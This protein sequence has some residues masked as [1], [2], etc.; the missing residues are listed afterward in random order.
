[1][2]RYLDDEPVQ[3]CP[4]SAGYRFRKFARRNKAVLATASVVAVAV[5][6]AVAVL[7]TS[8]V[9]IARALQAET[10]AKGELENAL[11][12][13]RRE[14]YFQR[15][16]LA[17]RELLEDNLLQAEELLD[18]CPADRR[19]WEWHYLKR[20]CHVEP[21]TVPDHSRRRWQTVAF[22]PDGRRLAT[23]GEDKT[24]K[25][26][27]AATGQELLT[28]PDTGEVSVRPFAPPTG[29]GSSP[30]TGVAP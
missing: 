28:L 23:A 8:T 24:V 6:L 10:E 1:M 15:I 3:A 26:W 17:H 5:L 29:A 22:S 2:Q 14:S 27:D 25:I 20:L 12:R 4:P 7:A 9:L 18:E 11:E 16:A 13:E 19:A 30:A 21:V